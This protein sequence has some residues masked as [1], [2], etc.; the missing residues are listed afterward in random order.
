L[1]RIARPLAKRFAF[2]G[3]LRW[4]NVPQNDGYSPSFTTDAGFRIMLRSPCFSGRSREFLSIV[5]CNKT[6]IAKVKSFDYELIPFGHVSGIVLQKGMGSAPKKATGILGVGGGGLSWA[7][8]QEGW[9]WP[10]MLVAIVGIGSAVALCVGA[11]AVLRDTHAW[12]RTHLENPTSRL[13]RAASKMRPRLVPIMLIAMGAAGAILIV[14]ALSGFLLYNPVKIAD[15]VPI[16]PIAPVS[17][18]LVSPPALVFPARSASDA[19]REILI[20]DKVLAVLR[21]DAEPRIAEGMNLGSNF[22]N[23]YL[24]PAHYPNYDEKW[25]AVRTGITGV[26]ATFIQ[27]KAQNPQYFDDDL[28]LIIDQFNFDTVRMPLDDFVGS[29]VILKQIIDRPKLS[30]GGTL[31][32]DISRLFAPQRAAFEKAL[33]SYREWISGSRTAL[34]KRR[35]ELSLIASRQK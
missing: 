20:I 29:L 28:S 13:S 25:S 6:Y 8:Q 32:D 22:W 7:A 21:E 27:M 1:S 2:S 26:N 35:S 15:G 4:P 3:R 17:H 11:V 24:D 5:R 33:N 31:Q 16:A 18:A 23:A 19:D 9:A 10:P 34:L 30:Q 14:A 12:I